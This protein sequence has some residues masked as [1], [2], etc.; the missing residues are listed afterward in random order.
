M[1]L[2]A[3][4][5]EGLPVDILGLLGEFLLHVQMFW[6]CFRNVSSL[7]VCILMEQDALTSTCLLI[8]HNVVLDLIVKR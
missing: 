1:G 3:R 8:N 2:A 6:V 7:P 4:E 5:R